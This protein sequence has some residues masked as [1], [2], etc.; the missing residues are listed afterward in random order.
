MSIFPPEKLNIK[1]KTN[2][3]AVSVDKQTTLI[4][5]IIL[6]VFKYKQISYSTIQSYGPIPKTF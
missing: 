4:C 6:A 1:M 2:C 3:T 5:G